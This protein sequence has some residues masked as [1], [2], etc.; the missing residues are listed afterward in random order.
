MSKERSIVGKIDSITVTIT[1]EMIN[2]FAKVS[3]D[4]NPIHVNEQYAKKTI[5][6]KRISHG[7]L[8]ASFISRVIANKLPG[9][10]TIYL[11]QNLSFKHPV[12][13]SRSYRT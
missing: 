12:S 2:N 8:V 3:G 13:Q 5:F 10:G 4:F 6:K 7:M 11:S 9:P 1:E